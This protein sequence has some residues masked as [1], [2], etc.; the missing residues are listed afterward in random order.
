MADQ[1]VNPE[2]LRCHCNNCLGDRNHRVLATEIRRT[3]AG[4]DYPEVYWEDTYQLVKC[5]GC[6]AVSMRLEEY[7]S[8]AHDEYDPG[9]RVTCYPPA[10]KRRF[11]PWAN[12]LPT[13]LQEL[14]IEVHT[15]TASDA[16]ALAAM[17]ARAIID[18]VANEKVGDCGG[19]QEKLKALVDG[20]FISSYDREFIEA[21]VNVG[22]AA[23]HRGHRPTAETINDLLDIVEH[24]LRG[25]YILRETGKKL[26]ALT[27]KRQPKPP[28]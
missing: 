17:G 5:C 1:Q 26:D 4:P 12:Q 25:A 28:Q 2:T 6:D 3:N 7:F 20:E 15:A 10:V 19:F 8:E 21:A 9:V 16:R 24:L 18:E 13:Q 14:L 11:P 23:A 27:P 22:N